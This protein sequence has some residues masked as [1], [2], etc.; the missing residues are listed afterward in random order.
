MYTKL[1]ILE[2]QVNTLY[3]ENESH[4]G[5]YLYSAID[6]IPPL[7]REFTELGQE[8]Q[9]QEARMQRASSP[10]MQ[11]FGHLSR[12]RSAC[13]AQRDLDRETEGKVGGQFDDVLGGLKDLGSWEAVLKWRVLGMVVGQRRREVE[14]R[15]DELLGVRIRVSGL[16]LEIVD[17]LSEEE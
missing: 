7:W 10:I 3:R 2:S 13:N 1:E 12:I 5:E 9:R 6:R 14:G 4:Y 11:F 17:A 15:L 16:L 8:Q